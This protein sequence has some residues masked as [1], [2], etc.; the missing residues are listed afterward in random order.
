V[1]N[2]DSGVGVSVSG[3]ITVQTS[4]DAVSEG[5]KPGFSDQGGTSSDD[6]GDAI[7]SEQMTRKMKQRVLRPKKILKPRAVSA[8]IRRVRGLLPPAK[9]SFSNF[10]CNTVALH[11]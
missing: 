10:T 1:Y 11:G 2:L 8:S 6:D 3:S 9:P 5:H 4:S 7:A